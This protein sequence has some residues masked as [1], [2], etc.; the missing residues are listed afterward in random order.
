MYTY[1]YS[2]WIFLDLWGFI[3]VPIIIIIICR[4]TEGAWRGWGCGCVTARGAIVPLGTQ[5][6]GVGVAIAGAVESPCAGETLRHEFPSCHI[7]ECARGTARSSG[8]AA[9]DTVEAFWAHVA[10]KHYSCGYSCFY[11]MHQV[12]NRYGRIWPE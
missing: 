3:N 6:S 7:E 5:A 12:N 4:L 1:S 10:C 9:R 11:A 2:E 8:H